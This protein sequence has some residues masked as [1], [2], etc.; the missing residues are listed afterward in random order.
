MSE[1][2]KEIAV[3]DAMRKRVL[4]LENEVREL[5][6]QLSRRAPQAAPLEVHG[7]RHDCEDCR[8]AV[9]LHAAPLEG[10]VAEALAWADGFEAHNLGV[11]GPMRRTFKTLASAYRSLLTDKD[12]ARS[13]DWEAQEK[14]IDA[15]RA[16]LK[17][18]AWVVRCLEAES[19]LAEALER[20]AVC[21]A[22][23]ADGLCRLRAERVKMEAVVEAAIKYSKTHDCMR[24]ELCRAVDALA[25]H[26][27][28]EG[29]A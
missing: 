24:C 28:T 3:N 12:R 25:S 17:G 21:A 29:G 11:D 27:K 1:L 9:A 20:I 19:K 23:N 6:A 26:S 13:E 5:R 10:E 22:D 2:E 15:L 16:E 14:M 8:K 18:S 7:P 4:G